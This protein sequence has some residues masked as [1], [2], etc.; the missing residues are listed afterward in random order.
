MTRINQNHF[1]IRVSPRLSAANKIFSFKK[2]CFYFK[3][4]DFF[5]NFRADT[6]SVYSKIKRFESRLQAASPE[7]LA[8]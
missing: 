3:T 7:R 5:Y 4:K 8:A 6:K 2:S 1:P